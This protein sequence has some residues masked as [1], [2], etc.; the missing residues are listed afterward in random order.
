MDAP[1]YPAGLTAAEASTTPMNIAIGLTLIFVAA[2]SA[3]GA[4]A[5]TNLFISL[6]RGRDAGR[7]IVGAVM[8][9]WCLY[10]AVWMLRGW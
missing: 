3:I 5:A 9:A 1:A 7:A 6:R 4:I 8:A 2:T 10:A